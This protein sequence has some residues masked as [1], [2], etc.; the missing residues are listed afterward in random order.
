MMRGEQEQKCLDSV[1][2]ILKT[3]K[4]C[5][6]CLDENDEFF[7]CINTAQ[8]N[9]QA[10]QFPDF[11]FEGGFIEH[12]QV[13]TAKE[14]SKGSA[15]KREEDEYKRRT[16]E[17]S[18]ENVRQWKNE[19]FRPN[20]I[21]TIPHELTFDKNSYEYF[22]DSFKRNF[23]KHIESLQKYNG[24]KEKGIFLIEQISAMLFIDGTY[25]AEPYSLFLDRNLL[26]YLYGFRGVLQYVVFTNGE[27]V[28]I[29]KLGRIPKIEH[30]APEKIAFIAGRTCIIKLQCFIDLQ[31]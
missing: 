18:Q 20:T 27:Y 13:S 21:T 24:Q 4:N 29:V 31:M 23:E 11:V 25:P 15:Y 2:S 7:D 8:A 10:S 16:E 6:G 1:K 9:T 30:Y 22:V 19:P 17:D 26:E 3:R 28:D 12:F 5:L 14:T